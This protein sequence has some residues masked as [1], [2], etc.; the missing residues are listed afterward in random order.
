MLSF[1][2][3]SCKDAGEVDVE[4]YGRLYTMVYWKLGCSLMGIAY[5]RWVVVF[6]ES[7][8]ALG[9]RMACVEVVTSSRCACSG[10]T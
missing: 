8:S 1:L 5:V 6:G 10:M 2:V 3:V 7:A 9:D 4:G